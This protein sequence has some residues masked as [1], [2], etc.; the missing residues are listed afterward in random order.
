MKLGAI[1]GIVMLVT[2]ICVFEWPRFKRAPKKRKSR[3]RHFI[4][5][6]NGIG[7]RAVILPRHS[8]PDATDRLY[9]QPLGR[10]LE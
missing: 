3:I 7:H 4:R 8:R 6:G 1:F 10:M 2:C 9:L 5:H